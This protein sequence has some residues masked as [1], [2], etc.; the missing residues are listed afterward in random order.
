MM[1]VINSL[2]KTFFVCELEQIVPSFYNKNEDE[3]FA[4]IM[5]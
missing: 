3:K 2:M 4:I 5:E 1:I